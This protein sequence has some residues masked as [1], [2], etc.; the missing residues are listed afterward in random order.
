MKFKQILQWQERT[1]A[2]IIS[3]KSIITPVSRAL[4]VRLPYVGF[5]WKYPLALTIENGDQETRVPIRDITRFIQLGLVIANFVALLAYRL[6]RS[7]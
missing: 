6:S 3:G 4:V 2:P 7:K 5:V 1:E